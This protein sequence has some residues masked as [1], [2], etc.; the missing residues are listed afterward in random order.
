MILYKIQEHKISW[1]FFFIPD[2]FTLGSLKCTKI[3]T[4]QPHFYMHFRISYFWGIEI[5]YT[6]NYRN[7]VNYFSSLSSQLSIVYF[8]LYYYALY[9]TSVHLKLSECKVHFITCRMRFW[10]HWIGEEEKGDIQYFR[11]MLE[12]TT[13]NL[14]W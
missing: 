3:F 11:Q 9:F 1:S 5:K 14:I 13:H 12:S 2:I 6:N 7:N 4:L 8:L 10:I